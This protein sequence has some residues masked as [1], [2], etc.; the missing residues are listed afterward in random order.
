MSAFVDILWVSGMVKTSPLVATI[1]VKLTIP[2]ALVVQVT[3]LKMRPDAWYWAGTACVC[4][5]FG[6]MVWK[7]S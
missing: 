6:L 3:W 7:K 2:L 1:G 4:T 5:A